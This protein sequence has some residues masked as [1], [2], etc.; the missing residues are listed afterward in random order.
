MSEEGNKN[1]KREK[2]R[3]MILNEIVSSEETYLERLRIT[4]EVYIGP[5]LER[6]LLS[7]EG[8]ITG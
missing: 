7:V 4:S 8:N 3:E 5:I 1:E 2:R 6:G